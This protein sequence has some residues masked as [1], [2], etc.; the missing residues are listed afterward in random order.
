[1]SYDL[2]AANTEAFSAGFQVSPPKTLARPAICARAAPSAPSVI[3]PH[4]LGVHARARSM[5]GHC[6]ESAP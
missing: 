2:R 5:R 6:L 4:G 3:L 1:M